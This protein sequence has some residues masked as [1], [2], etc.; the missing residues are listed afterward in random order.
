MHPEVRQGPGNCPICGMT[1]EPVLAT[2]ETGPSRELVDMTRRFCI[3]LVVALPVLLLER[4]PSQRPRPT[5]W[6]ARP[7]MDPVRARH[8][9]CAMGRLAVLRSRARSVVTLRL[10]MF[11]LIAMGM[12]VAWAYSVVA[13]VAQIFPA[14]FRDANGR[15]RYFEA[16][17]GIIVLVLLGQAHQL[18][19]REMTS[20]AIRTLLDLAPKTARRIK[21]DGG[22]E[23]VGLRSGRRRRS[24]ARPPRRESASRRGCRRGPQR[25][26]RIDGHRRIDADHQGVGAKII[27]GT[28]NQ[29]GG[30]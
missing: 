9:G 7:R 17:A 29:S 16:A 19:A 18:R 14:A 4:R 28:I 2:A 22:E 6:A 25:C 12:G 24:P 26:R 23:E 1:L 5:F 21:P 27:G 3:G 30:R 20:G 10:N 11:T 15:R 8:S 13:T